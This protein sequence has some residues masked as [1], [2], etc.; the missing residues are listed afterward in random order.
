MANK[1][2][3]RINAEYQRAMADTLRT[4]KDP[5]I[6]GFTSVIRCEVS[7][8]LRWAKVYISV[9][10]GDKKEVLRGLKAATGYI[11]RAVSEMISLRISPE[12]VFYF[13]ESIQHGASIIEKLREINASGALPD[14]GREQ[15]DAGDDDN[16]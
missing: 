8:D 11:R 6:S 16:E 9:M 10:D 15:V 12:P 7:G 1:R 4:I 14:K 3:N 2:I 5:R 13:D